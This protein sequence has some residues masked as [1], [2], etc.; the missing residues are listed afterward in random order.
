V[1]ETA[2]IN[3]SP[4]ILLCR[5]EKLV[6]LH[7]F[8]AHIFVPTAVAKEILAR[9]KSDVTAKAIESTPWIEIIP[10]APIPEAI[11]SWGLGLG[12][13]SV[14]AVAAA[15]PDVT[16]IIDDLNGRKCAVSLGIPVR[17]TLGIVLAAKRRGVI[18]QARPVLE[19]LIASGLYLQR[20]ILDDALRRV[21][22]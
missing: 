14:L 9:G 10:A 7:E 8:A 6:L 22:E 1:D 5:A 18:R 2:V 21:G 16:A 19:D 11:A 13:S 17:G 3:A 15:R 20:Q 4:L 12:E